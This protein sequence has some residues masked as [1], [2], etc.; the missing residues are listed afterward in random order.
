MFKFIYDICQKQRLKLFGG[1]L[2]FSFFCN[3]LLLTAPLYMLQIYNRVIS[4]NNLNTL[5]ML[6]L[7]MLIA[8]VFMAIFDWV[9]H[10]IL[11]D[12]A[13]QFEQSQLPVIYRHTLSTSPSDKVKLSAKDLLGRMQFVKNFIQSQGI[14]SFLDCLWV[15]F[16]V[17]ILFAFHSYLGI[18]ACLSL[19]ALSLIN[20]I[21]SSLIKTPQDLATVKQ[22]QSCSALDSIEKQSESI[23]AMGMGDTIQKRWLSKHLEYRNSDYKSQNLSLIFNNLSKNIRQI[24]QSLILGIGC[25]LVVTENFSAGLMIAS[26]I[27]LGRIL[28]PFESIIKHW[29]IFL[30]AKRDFEL[31]N[32][33]EISAGSTLESLPT[34]EAEVEFIGAKFGAFKGGLNQQYTDLAFEPG[35]I[36]L[37]QGPSGSGKTSI[38]R[39]ILGLDTPTEGDVRIGGISTSQL[40]DENRKHLIGFVS[41]DVE[42]LDGT[43]SENISKFSNAN[44]S[45]VIKICRSVGLHQAILRLPQNYSTKISSKSKLLSGGQKQ[46]LTIARALFSDPQLLVF[47]EPDA[48]LDQHSRALFSE[49]ILKLRAEGKCIIIVSHAD[50]I[51]QCADFR[52]QFD[53]DGIK[54]IANIAKPKAALTTRHLV[55][56]KGQ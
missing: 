50:Y 35:K 26:S 15:P 22:E 29:K 5:L 14:T 19:L 42:I 54:K 51:R 53:K 3:L 47:D 45:K 7:I 2:I 41:Q 1:L 16:Y 13:M 30:A 48:N 11:Q 18:F 38:C 9:R 46:L 31:L 34:P 17:L 10:K 8:M 25:F 36:H 49:L 39:A 27:L 21:N 44:I 6:S 40:S 55:H 24:A 33:I 28:A 23:V 4:T 43:I 20:K 37:I 32:Q 52:Y 56:R 12:A